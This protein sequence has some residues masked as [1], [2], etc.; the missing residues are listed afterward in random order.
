MVIS[1]GHAASSAT[2]LVGKF[3]VA[4][5]EPRVLFPAGVEFFPFG[6]IASPVTAVGGGHDACTTTTA[7]FL[8]N[9]LMEF[10]CQTRLLRIHVTFFEGFGTS[11]FS[12]PIL[13]FHV[14]TLSCAHRNRK[15]TTHCHAGP[16]V[17]PC[18][19]CGATGQLCCLSGLAKLIRPRAN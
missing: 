5:V 18:L 10:G 8:G 2:G 9:P 16:T 15:P 6:H 13:G 14:S 17:W 7:W 11:Q 12:L 3:N 1:L 19:V 4:I